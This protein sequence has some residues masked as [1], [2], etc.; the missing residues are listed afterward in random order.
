MVREIGILMRML[1]RRQKDPNTFPAIRYPNFLNTRTVNRKE[2]KAGS[3][4]LVY[5][6]EQIIL[7][8]G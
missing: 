1:G 4:H 7:W 6:K 3:F 2:N 5:R 8:S